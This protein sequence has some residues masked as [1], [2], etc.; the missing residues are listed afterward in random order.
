MPDCSRFLG[1]GKTFSFLGVDMEQFRTFHIFYIIEYPNQID[2]VV[3]I[4]GTKITDVHT[5]ENVLLL[6]SHRLQTITETYQSLSTVF[7][8]QSE[9]RHE[10][11]NAVSYLIISFG[12]SELGDAQQIILHAAYTAVDTHVV[13]FEYDEHVV[14]HCRNIIQSFER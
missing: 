9:A 2:N 11:G 4:N 8:H 3:T 1:R 14:V 10:S 12:S 5:V 6:C 13:V 7:V